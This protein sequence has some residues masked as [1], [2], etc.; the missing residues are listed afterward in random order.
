MNRLPL[1]VV[2]VSFLA[3]GAAF[4]QLTDGM[5]AGPLGP[6]VWRESPRIVFDMT[7]R[8]F[9]EIL[10]SD[11]AKVVFRFRNEGTG[12][13]TIRNVHAGCGCTT[14]RLNEEQK[15]YM[16][17]ETGTITVVFNPKGRSGQQTQQVTMVTNDPE[18]PNPTLTIHA[19]VQRVVTFE[20]MT[21]QFGQV[22]KGE[23]KTVEVRAI[24][25]TPDFRVEDVNITPDRTKFDVEVGETA[26]IERDGRKVRATT[27]RF[28]VKP[29]ATSGFASH[30]AM[31]RTNDKREE[32]ATLHIGAQILSDVQ[33]SPPAVSLG[34]LEP[35]QEFQGEVRVYS[36]SGR[37]FRIQRVE[38]GGQSIDGFE[39]KVVGA[40]NPSMAASK[41]DDG[42]AYAIRFKGRAPSQAGLFGAQLLAYTD[43]D[44]D[45]PVN[46]SLRAVIR[47]NPTP[48]P[49]APSGASASPQLK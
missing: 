43:A 39:S 29:N 25:R 14:P 45:E 46:I 3:A 26:E 2:M 12:P 31:V 7:Q 17:G 1:G 16:P 35:G 20:P 41:E 21:V 23:S 19:M 36:G 40:I 4:G 27:L 30:Q 32:F 42:S 48:P 34:T 33:A 15:D 44:P 13:L 38:L 8:D 5:N 18:S 24:G 49:A 22:K 37:P 28:T 6:M 9:G 11:E 10:S 47:V